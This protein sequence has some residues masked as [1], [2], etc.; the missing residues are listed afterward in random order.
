VYREAGKDANGNVITSDNVLTRIAYHD[1]IRIIR[2][3]LK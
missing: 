1:D 3:P 2:L